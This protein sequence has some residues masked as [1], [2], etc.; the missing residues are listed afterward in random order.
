VNKT[1]CDVT[2]DGKDCDI[3][4][5]KCVELTSE[6]QR[7][8]LFPLQFCFF[9]QIDMKILGLRQGLV[10][11]YHTSSENLLETISGEHFSVPQLK[12]S[13]RRHMKHEIIWSKAFVPAFMLST[14][15]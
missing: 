11:L 9:F 15:T 1:F 10:Y 5:K 6:N 2:G 12:G 13:M 3:S 8:W 7:T 14:H 4:D